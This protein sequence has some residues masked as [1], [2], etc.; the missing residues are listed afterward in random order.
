MRELYGYIGTTLHHLGWIRNKEADSA[1]ID[2]KQRGYTMPFTSSAESD[3][4]F[5]TRRA[6]LPVVRK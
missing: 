6:V 1:I 4:I 2:A 3:G 5:G